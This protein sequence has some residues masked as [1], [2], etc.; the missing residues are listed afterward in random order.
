MTLANH[1]TMM[2][3]PYCTF[4]PCGSTLYF[5]RRQEKYCILDVVNITNFQRVLRR[6]NRIFIFFNCQESLN[7]VIQK[8]LPES[9]VVFVIFTLHFLNT[10]NSSENRNPDNG[11]L[12]GPYISSCDALLYNI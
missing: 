12:N 5:Q 6:E 8:C 7:S 1:I 9:W 4:L 11:K 2:L 3:I 10:R